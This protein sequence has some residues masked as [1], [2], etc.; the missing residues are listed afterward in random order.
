ML[1]E[2]YK[3]V[4]PKQAEEAASNPVQSGFESQGRHSWTKEETRAY[5]KARYEQQK[6]D[7]IHYLGGRCNRCE[8]TSDLEID[9]MV[10]ADKSFDV[11]KMWGVKRLPSVYEELEKCQLLCHSCH[12]I[13]TGDEQRGEYRGWRHGTSTGWM[14]KKC[15]C[16]ECVTARRAWYDARNAK[17]R[18]E[19]Q[20]VRG[21]RSPYGR[22]STHGEKLHYT[23]GCR[24]AECRAANAA[25]A[26]SLR[27]ASC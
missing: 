7:M 11:G 27:E 10:K 21:P 2:G 15:R 13:K 6:A 20:H 26:R 22:P 25:Y 5:M 9:H 8:A 4:Y 16:P 14:R 17:R 1:K 23:R 19:Y 18:A 24:C 12:L 3:P